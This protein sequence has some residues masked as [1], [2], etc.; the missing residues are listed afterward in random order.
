MERAITGFHQDETGDWVAELDCGHDQHVRHRPPFQVR[1]W[2]LTR[3]GRTARR[4]QPLD[5]PL[6]DRGE[7]PDG[8]GYV[9]T[10]PE[11]TE[12]TLPSGLRRDHRLAAGT[13][14][15]LT[16]HHGR[17][18]FVA[19]GPPAVDEVLVSGSTRGIPPTAVHHVDPLGPIHLT[20]DFFN[21]D[22]A[23]DASAGPDE[24]GD[25]ACWAGMVCA[26]C[27]AVLDGGAHRPG[28]PSGA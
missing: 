21:V 26:E 2:V 3:E 24:G 23:R 10:S 22:P 19:P 9:R 28:C 12:E 4:R 7:L 8:V 1:E 11:W 17:V 16:V 6:C 25:P 14:G 18:R 5:C 15:R 20:I 27:G 13:W